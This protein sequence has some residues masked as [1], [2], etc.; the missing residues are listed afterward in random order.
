R[1]GR[2]GVPVP[3]CGAREPCRHDHDVQPRR[4]ARRA[5]RRAGRVHLPD[6]PPPARADRRRARRRPRRP[7]RAA[8]FT[9]PVVEDEPL[10]A[11]LRRVH[12]LL[13]DGATRLEAHELLMG[14]ILAVVERHATR[15][16]AIGTAGGGAVA[17]G[18][19]AAGG[20]AGGIITGGGSNGG[21]R[22]SGAAAR[23]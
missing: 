11:R 7:G 13:L 23:V 6:A 22:G 1:A 10:A 20:L 9:A 21:A 18:S 2:P 8:A 3:R 17:A 14:T 15:P 4:P 16:L 12:A 5:Q 19:P